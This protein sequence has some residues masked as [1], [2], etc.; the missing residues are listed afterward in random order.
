M[1][2]GLQSGFLPSC[3]PG[4]W[5]LW[6]WSI[7]RHTRSGELTPAGFGAAVLWCGHLHPLPAPGASMAHLLDI[8][9]IDLLPIQLTSHTFYFSVSF[10]F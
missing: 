3:S 9:S 6:Q 2:W 1:G 7:T 5:P 8:A 4:S 10:L